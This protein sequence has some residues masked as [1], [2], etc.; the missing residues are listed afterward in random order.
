MNESFVSI[1]VDREERPDIDR[2]YMT[3]VQALNGTGG[4]PLT[5]FLSPDLI[6]KIPWSTFLLFHL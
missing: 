3:F 1:K 6:R 4:W 5:V 2:Q